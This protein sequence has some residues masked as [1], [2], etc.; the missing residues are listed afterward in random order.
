MGPSASRLL[1]WAQSARSTTNVPPQSPHPQ[2]PA[3]KLINFPLKLLSCPLGQS[4]PATEP[5]QRC[6]L[7]FLCPIRVSDFRTPPD[8]F[9]TLSEHARFMVEHLDAQR[10]SRAHVAFFPLNLCSCMIQPPPILIDII[11]HTQDLSL[12]YISHGYAQSPR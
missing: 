7:R 2:T 5:A 8:Q 12:A 11:G 9:W 4:K 3:S 1:I 6:F 10:I